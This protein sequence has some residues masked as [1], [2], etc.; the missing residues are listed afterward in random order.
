MSREMQT[1]DP[2]SLGA[3]VTLLDRPDPVDLPRRA[4]VHRYDGDPDRRLTRLP[5]IMMAWIQHRH[6]EID[7]EEPL[8]AARRLWNR[9]TRPRNPGLRVLRPTGTG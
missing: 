1:Y 2:V 7:V 8:V 5:P 9:Q 3:F 4:H 6:L